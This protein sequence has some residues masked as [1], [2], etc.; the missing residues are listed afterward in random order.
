MELGQRKQT[1]LGTPEPKAFGETTLVVCPPNSGSWKQVAFWGLLSL[2]LIAPAQAPW[3]SVCIRSPTRAEPTKDQAAPPAGGSP[4]QS[5]NITA[6]FFPHHPSLFHHFQP[7]LASHTDRE[8]E[9][10]PLHLA[11]G[12][13]EGRTGDNP[14]EQHGPAVPCISRIASRSV[15]SQAAPVPL[16]GRAFA[17]Q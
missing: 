11:P 5:R 6:S 15:L 8:K 7:D 17:V 4:Q 3:T 10:T 9:H 13:T 16:A 2:C 14:G 1:L 12:E